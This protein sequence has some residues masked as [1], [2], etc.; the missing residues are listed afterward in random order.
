MQS[1]TVL[2]EVLSKLRVGMPTYPSADPDAS[3]GR[4]APGLHLAGKMDVAAL[5]EYFPH[6]GA[7]QQAQLLP[8]RP[9]V[10]APREFLKAALRAQQSQQV[11]TM[12]LLT[13]HLPLVACF[14]PY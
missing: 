9:I 5:A 13:T 6:P 1:T 7:S 14:W 11:S 10:A 4:S 3:R 2:P 8:S 12:L